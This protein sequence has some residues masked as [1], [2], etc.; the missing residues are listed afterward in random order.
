MCNPAPSS[1]VDTDEAE[2]PRH[3]RDGI[4]PEAVPERV[5]ALREALDGQ[6][7]AGRTPHTNGAAPPRPPDAYELDRPDI[8]AEYGPPDDGDGWTP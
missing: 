8:G 5:A 3:L 6:R 7:G 1:G 2:L 4:A